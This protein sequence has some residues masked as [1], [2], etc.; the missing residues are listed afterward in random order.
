MARWR[1]CGDRLTIYPPNTPSDAR[2][3]RPNGDRGYRGYSVYGAP[4]ALRRLCLGRWELQT[5]FFLQRAVRAA[6]PKAL[7]CCLYR[8]ACSRGKCQDGT[9]KSDTRVSLAATNCN[10]WAHKQGQSVRFL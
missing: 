4:A 5:H 8:E 9:K 3:S 6:P 10:A 1:A 7:P 2:R